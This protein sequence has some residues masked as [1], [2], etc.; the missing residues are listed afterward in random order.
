MDEKKRSKVSKKAHRK[1][2]NSDSNNVL[3]EDD[4]VDE[5]IRPKKRT[6]EKIKASLKSPKRR[7][8]SMEDNKSPSSKE[9][10]PVEADLDKSS[11]DEGAK[12]SED[13]DSHSS[14]E[15][16]VKVLPF[17]LFLQENSGLMGNL[18]C[19]CFQNAEETREANSSVWKT[20]RAPQ[21]NNQILW[22]G[23]FCTAL[24]SYPI[25]YAQ[26]S[27]INYLYIFEIVFLQQFIGG[28]NRLLKANVKPS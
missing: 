18:L 26:S 22:D 28:P 8:K 5:E 12:S 17:I 21:V 9:K 24:T 23:V 27:I 16:E 2:D 3:S 13:G 4:E 19:S 20:S 1:S 6:A 25:R 15:E 11:E 7:K 14:A 10:R